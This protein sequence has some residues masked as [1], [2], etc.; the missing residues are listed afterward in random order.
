[1]RILNKKLKLFFLI[2]LFILSSIQVVLCTTSAPIVYVA[3]DGT[4]DLN[5]N[6][7]NAQVQ[8]NQALQLV[9]G[10]PAYTTVHL[11]GPFTYVINDTIL[12]GSNT[13]LEGDPTAV[14]KVAD[15]AGWPTMKPLIKQIGNSGNDN[16]TIRGFEINGNYAGNSEF[17][18]GTGYYNLIYITHSTNIK[19]YNMYMHDGMGDGLRVNTGNNVQFYNNT[20]YKLGHD[21]LFA[22]NFQNVEAWN[23]R[24]T[25]RT[26]SG[27]RDWNSNG[28][29]FHDNVIDSFYDWSA[30]GPGIQ[31]EKST[32]GVINNVEICNN[33]IHNT[34]GPGI[35]LIA[36]GDP[37]PQEEAQNVYIHHNTLYNTGTNPNINWVGGIVASGFYNTLIENNVFDGVYHA[38]I[39]HTYPETV[40]SGAAPSLRSPAGATNYARVGYDDI[41]QT[42]ATNLASVDS[43]V[44]SAATATGLAPVGSGYTTTVRNNIIVNTLKRTK[45]PTGTG[46]AVIN[47]LPETHTV[48]VDNNCLYNNTGGNYKNASSTT[49]IYVDPLF[50]DQKNHNYYLKSKAGRWDG[51]SWVTDSISSPCIDAGYPFSD[52]SNEP[53]P[54]GDRINIGPHGNTKYA[55]KSVPNIPI[56]QVTSLTPNNGLNTGTNT[57]TIGG[58]GFTGAT[59]V[60]FGSTAATNLAIVSDT[61]ITVA[62]PAGTGTIDVTV[63]TPG[64]TSATSANSK[65]IYNVPIPQ[66]TSLTPNNGLNTGANTVTIGGTGFTGTTQVKFGPNTAT[67][68]VVTDTQITVTAPAGTGTVDV[69]V[70]TPGG[71]SATSANSRYTYNIPAPKPTVTSLTPNSGLNTGAN[72]VTIKGTGL[73]GATQVKFGSTAAANLAIASDTQI[74]VTAPA[75][76]GTVDVT[77]TTP[78]G[79]SA[80]SA[81]SKYTYN[82]PARPTVTSLTPNNGLNTGGN[83]VTIVGTG[84]TGATQVKFGSTAATSLV[85]VSGTQI[86]VTAPAGTGTVYVTVTTPGGTSATSTNS[87]YTYNAPARPTVSSLTPNNG[88][89]TGANTVTIKGTGFT[90][91]TQVKF[92]SNTATNLVVVSGTQITVTAPAGTGT[93]YVTVTTPGGT[94]TTSLYSRYTYRSR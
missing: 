33:V 50:A 11:K 92:G 71:T 9:A 57:V 26:N 64:G 63:T 30:G 6:G 67:N 82:V 29:K 39:A 73:T 83:T 8:I 5:C 86:T 79:T 38:A 20:V 48:T 49:D 51:S 62:A 44:M 52:Y 87:R 54:N 80:T 28:L 27:L 14:I 35:W 61:Q 15:H 58:T 40:T 37:Y 56:P 55:S 47:Y 70:T 93:V 59:Q 90:G 69:T 45:D 24:I 68:L 88:L 36:Y 18:L 46:Y 23:N 31:I 85:V 3:G 25:C 10:N 81:N 2:N 21:G 91:A 89:N 53:L 1:V 94:S 76:T 60:K 34:Y 65:Y 12:I 17:A 42:G 41:S 75:G 84:F 13:I 4:G 74:T 7:T 32:G 16:I 22:I 77:V 78:G 66:V 19:V 43:G 72:T